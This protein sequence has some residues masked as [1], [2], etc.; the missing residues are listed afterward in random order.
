MRDWQHD[1][2]QVIRCAAVSSTISAMSTSTSQPQPGL[3][4]ITDKEKVQFVVELARAVSV[5]SN[6]LG[7]S[8]LASK[9]ASTLTVKQS[10]TRRIQ[11]VFSLMARR[12]VFDV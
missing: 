2:R 9:A 3:D 5:N 8:M 4:Q 6:T 12:I 11:H 1:L 7:I 10:L